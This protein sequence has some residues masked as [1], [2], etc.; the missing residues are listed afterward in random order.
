MKALQRQRGVSVRI[1]ACRPSVDAARIAG[2]QW[3]LL[4][5][6]TAGVRDE[7]SGPV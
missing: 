6:A 1:A 7:H 5:A 2:G 3:R 4:G